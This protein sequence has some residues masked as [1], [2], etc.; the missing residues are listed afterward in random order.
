MSGARAALTKAFKL[1][2]GPFEVI[3]E[4]VASTV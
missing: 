3:C 1:M 2:N 4:D